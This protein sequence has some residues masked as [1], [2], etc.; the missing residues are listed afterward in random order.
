MLQSHKKL[1]E[2]IT[3][4]ELSAGGLF[5]FMCRCHYYHF[6]S[7]ILKSHFRTSDYRSE[8]TILVGEREP[9]NHLFLCPLP[10]DEVSW[11][12]PSKIFSNMRLCL[13]REKSRA[14]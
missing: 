13:D 1:C 7:P 11:K 9:I 2:V 10:V 12:Y 8:G 5:L 6:F 3:L 14:S 4:T